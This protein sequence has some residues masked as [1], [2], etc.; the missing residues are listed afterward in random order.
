MTDPYA[1]A[2]EQLG[3]D[4]LDVRIVGIYA[5]EGI[6]ADHAR[7]HPKVMEKLTAFIREHSREPWLTAGRGAEVP[8]WAARRDVQAA[9]TVVGRRAAEHN[10]QGQPMDLAGAVLDRAYLA[11]AY[12]AGANLTDAILPRAN[13]TGAELGGANLT[14]A[15][16][17]RA[18]LTGAELGGA[19]L[20]GANLT[21]A[22][23]TDAILGRAN[24]T[25]ADLTRANLT[26][27]ALG[28][29]AQGHADLRGA[30]LRGADLYGAR[31][32]EGVQVPDGWMADDGSGRLKR[33]GRLS[34]VTDHY[35]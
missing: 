3:S 9:F 25:D 32:P 17:P 31:W 7:Q 24:L 13:L 30:D 21:D 23:L 28:H 11:G 8:E 20:T 2:I 6:A 35:L 10:I 5:L 22:E 18:N 12:F 16:L 26:G 4:K 1:E 34:E 33:A 14:D 19:D 29:A 15:V 27:A